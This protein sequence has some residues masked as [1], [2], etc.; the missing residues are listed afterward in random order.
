[1]RENTWVVVID[2]T[3]RCETAHGAPVDLGRGSLA[4]LEPTERRTLATEGGARIL[5]ILTPWP[6]PGHYAE[7]EQRGVRE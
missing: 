1:V 3:L 6:G 2:G 5:L 4:R 7:L